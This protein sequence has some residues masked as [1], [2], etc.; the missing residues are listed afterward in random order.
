M[1][2][3]DQAAGQIAFVASVDNDVV[4]QFDFTATATA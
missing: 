4:L 3:T 2:A 1:P